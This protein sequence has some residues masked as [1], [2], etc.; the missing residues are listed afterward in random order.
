M[1]VCA[2]IVLMGVAGGEAEDAQFYA[3]A[4]GLPG[5]RQ[6]GPSC[7][8]F[9]NVPALTAVSGINIADGSAVSQAFISSV[10]GLRDGDFALRE[11]FGKEEFFELFGME[12]EGVKIYHEA[13]KMSGL[14]ADAERLGEEVFEEKLREGKFISL[15]VNGAMGRP[16]NILLMGCREGRYLYH[17]P[18]MGKRERGAGGVAGGGDGGSAGG[19]DRVCG[20]GAGED[21]DVFRRRAGV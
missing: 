1:V 3:R 17:D 21:V 8:F 7:G 16:H 18:T 6:V 9:A 14:V 12:A 13:G 2:V 19:V 15:R 5:A 4:R 20:G 10:Y 11:S